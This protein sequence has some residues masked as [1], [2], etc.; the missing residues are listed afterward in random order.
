MI[1]DI[2]FLTLLLAFLCAVYAVVAAIYG[3]RKNDDRWVRSAR[4]GLIVVFPLLLLAAGLVI[5][6]L[7]TGDFSIAYVSH[8]SSRGMPTYLKVTA[9]WGGQAGSL[10]FWNVL[11]SAFTCAAMLSKWREQKELMPYVIIVSGMTQIFFLL[12]STF[13]EDPFTRN[14]VI[15]PD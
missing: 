9:L 14:V 12:I 15:P 3:I 6:A 10:L 8:V 11:L 1:A 4:N 5:T 13:V 2:G 7:V